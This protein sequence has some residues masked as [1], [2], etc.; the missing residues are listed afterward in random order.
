MKVDFYISS[1]SSG[2]AE[3]VLTNLAA[4]FAEHDM[5]VSIT[6]YEKRPQFYSVASNVKLNKYNF[7]N[8]SKLAEWLCDYRATKK[9]LQKR[10]AAVAISFLSR[11]IYA[12]SGRTFF[13]DK[14]YCLR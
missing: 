7:T 10:K 1:L 3:H 9:Y 2:G 14:N 12:D 13:K 4:N 11:C 8:K 6:S 5:D